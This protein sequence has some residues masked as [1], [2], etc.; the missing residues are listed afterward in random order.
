MRSLA[1]FLPILALMGLLS[2]MNV[3]AMSRSGTPASGKL[4][5][6]APALFLLAWM[7]QD[8]RRRRCVPCHE[9]GFLSAVYL[10]ASLIWYLF[11]SRGWKGFLPLA[12]F[13]GMLLVPWIASVVTYLILS[14]E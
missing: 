6:I 5:E 4:V 14:R 9:F 12:A 10:P 13:V 2:A 8:A 1:P 3:A 7:I 11:W